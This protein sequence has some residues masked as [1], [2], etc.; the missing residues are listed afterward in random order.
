LLQVKE[1]HLRWDSL[2]EFLALAVSIEE[3]AAKTGNAKAATVAAALNAA[4]G[5]VLSENKSPG[6]KVGLIDNRGSHFYL[7][8]Y[9]AEALAT[10]GGGF[11]AEFGP[12]ASAL[13]SNE[14]TI[15]AELHELNGTKV[16]LGG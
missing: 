16:D 6:R 7:A 3:L 15:L 5:R 9:W 11:A 10:E 13:A 1:N 8:L 2:G 12:L 4:V 14:T